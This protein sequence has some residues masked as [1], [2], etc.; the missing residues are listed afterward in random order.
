MQPYGTT[1]NCIDKEGP[2]V[3]ANA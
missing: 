1:G 3:Q 2:M